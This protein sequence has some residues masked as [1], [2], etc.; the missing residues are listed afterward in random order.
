MEELS[1]DLIA[2]EYMWL[3]NTDDGISYPSSAGRCHVVLPSAA[4]RRD[5]HV[6][7]R[8]KTPPAM[9]EN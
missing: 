7:V 3:A 5:L 6:G 2:K 4:L 8:D 9:R 1:S